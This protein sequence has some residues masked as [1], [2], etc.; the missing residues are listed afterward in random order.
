MDRVYATSRIAV[1]CWLSLRGFFLCLV[2]LAIYSNLTVYNEID[3][4]S[5][6]WYRDLIQINSFLDW[7]IVIVLP[8][9]SLIQA[10]WKDLLWSRRKSHL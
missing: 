7:N 3:T 6:K 2:S 9:V 10:T 4:I 8:E 1:T 5:V